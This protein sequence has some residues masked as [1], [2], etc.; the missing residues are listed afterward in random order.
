MTT[1][2]DLR[3]GYAAALTTPTAVAEAFLAARP[4]ERPWQAF[5]SVD[6]EDVRAQA[7]E[8]GIRVE[9]DSSGN[10][11]PKQ[12]RNAEVDKIPVIAVV[13]EQEVKEKSLSIRMRKGG[14]LGMHS[15]HHILKALQVSHSAMD[16]EDLKKC[17]S[18][19]E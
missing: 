17:V 12:V 10:R 6:A 18:G 19:S 5:R 16:V 11:L 1:V 2:A 8:L 14:D 13:G 7:Q 15:T 4:T 3:A 9:V